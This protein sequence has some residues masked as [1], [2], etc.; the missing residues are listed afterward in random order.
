MPTSTSGSIHLSPIEAY[1]ALAPYYDSLRASREQYLSAIDQ[2]VISEARGARTLLDVGS[3]NGARALRIAQSVGVTDVVLLEPSAGM[4]AQC[5]EEAEYWSCEASRIPATARKFDLIT[6]L[7]NTLGHLQDARERAE[8]LA[9]LKTLLTPRGSIF[10]DV[11]HRYNGRNYG[12]ARTAF[13]VLHD[14]VSPAES[15]GDVLTSWQAGAERICT[16]GHVF[17]QRELLAIF[18]NAGVRVKAR[19]VVDYETGGARRFSFLGNLLYQ[20]AE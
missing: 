15:N 10:L 14:F 8:V 7:W 12:W 17:T 13:R 16:H 11:N 9:R 19:W 6:C 18:N 5:R 4:R 2:I 3:G 1:D 20:L